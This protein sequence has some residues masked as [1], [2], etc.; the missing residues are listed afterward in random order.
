[1][2]A[3]DI[4]F[5]LIFCVDRVSQAVMYTFEQSKTK[6]NMFETICYNWAKN[7]YL[8]SNQIINPASNDKSSA[9]IEPIVAIQYFLGSQH[10]NII[11]LEFYD[12]LTII[13]LYT[14]SKNEIKKY[15]DASKS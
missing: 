14:I 1:M 7:C 5:T 12:D 10:R 11:A 9:N 2:P 6:E 4:N 13:E 15:V 8:I 3:C